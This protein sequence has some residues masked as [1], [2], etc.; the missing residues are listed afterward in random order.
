V[1][2]RGKRLLGGGLVLLL[3]GMAAALTGLGKLPAAAGWT[4]VGLAAAAGL[5]GVLLTPLAE[6]LRLRIATA[7]GRNTAV[8]SLLRTGALQEVLVHE[9]DPI[10]LG[11]HPAWKLPGAAPVPPYVPRTIDAELDRKLASGG[12]VII[13]GDSAAGKSRAA[14]EALRRNAAR[15]GWRSVLVP[16]DAAALRTLAEVGSRLVPRQSWFADV[17]LGL[18]LVRSREARRRRRPRCASDTS[19]SCPNPNARDSTP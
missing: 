15:L 19:W 8:Q 6:R 1:P 14:Y 2:S 18:M 11:V 16:R 7:H 4:A 13:Q 10:G 12:L 17:W 5:S 9:A 3:A